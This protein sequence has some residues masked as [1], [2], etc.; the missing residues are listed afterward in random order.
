MAAPFLRE[1]GF[2]DSNSLKSHLQMP[3]LMTGLLVGMS[4]FFFALLFIFLKQ[5]VPQEE[6]RQADVADKMLNS[7]DDPEEQPSNPDTKDGKIKKWIKDKM[8]M[9]SSDGMKTKVVLFSCITMLFYSGMSITYNQFMPTY[10][11]NLKGVEISAATASYIHSGMNYASTIARGLFILVALRIKPEF[12]I[13][14]NCSMIS[15][16]SFLLLFVGNSIRMTWLSNILI[17]IGSASVSAPLYSFIRKYLEVTNM[18]GSIFVFSSGLTSVFFPLLMGKVLINFPQFLLYFN[19]INIALTLFF[20]TLIYIMLKKSNNKK[21]LEQKSD[22]SDPQQQQT[23]T[24][25]T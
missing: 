11:Q 24:R 10:L 8:I 12:I 19:L 5:E 18:T 9:S 15:L 4:G 7:G 20:F 1:D 22:D 3:Y 6:T 25:D 14:F 13:Y 21:S 17:G 23:S 2:A 16:G